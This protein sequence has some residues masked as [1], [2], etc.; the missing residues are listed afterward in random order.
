MLEVIHGKFYA[1]VAIVGDPDYLSKIDRM[2]IGSNGA[3]SI[4]YLEGLSSSR[5]MS[6]NES[7]KSAVDELKNGK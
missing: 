2:A 4:E 6:I 7:I 5:V 3:V 1:G